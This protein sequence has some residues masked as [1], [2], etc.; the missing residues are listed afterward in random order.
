MSD[1]HDL[2]SYLTALEAIG[3]LARV[4]RSVSLNHELADVSFGPEAEG[5]IIN[6]LVGKAL[7]SYWWPTDVDLPVFATAYGR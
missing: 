3:Q 2:Q 5:V 6:G 1:I 7:L 4:R